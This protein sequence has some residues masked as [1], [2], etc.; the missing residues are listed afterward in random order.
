[1]FNKYDL[2]KSNK[3]QVIQSES[4]RTGQIQ[5]NPGKIYVNPRATT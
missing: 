5:R 1:M 4:N 2:T 3:Q